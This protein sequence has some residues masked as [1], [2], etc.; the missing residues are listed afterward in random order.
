MVNISLC[1]GQGEFDDSC[2][3]HLEDMSIIL[4]NWAKISKIRDVIKTTFW[5][6][7]LNLNQTRRYKIAF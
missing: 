6:H 7:I 2:A 5:H 1:S 3:I 4:N